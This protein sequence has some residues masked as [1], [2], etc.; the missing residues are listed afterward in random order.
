MD[1][2]CHIHGIQSTYGSTTN[3][4]DDIENDDPFYLQFTKENFSYTPQFYH[5]L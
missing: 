5:L 2:S 3:N 1:R 4:E